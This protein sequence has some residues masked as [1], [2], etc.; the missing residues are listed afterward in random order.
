LTTFTTEDRENCQKY[1]DALRR[2]WYRLNDTNTDTMTIEQI[3]FHAGL[4]AGLTT[5]M[6]LLRETDSKEIS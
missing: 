2:E 6:N 3:R 4:K 1:I 5:A